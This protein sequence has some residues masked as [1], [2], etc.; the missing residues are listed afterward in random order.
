MAFGVNRSPLL[1]IAT[2]QNHARKCREEFPDASREVQS[3]MHV[4]DCVNGTDYAGVTV[5][6]QQSIDK[7]MELG[8]INLIKWA[9]I[10]KEVLSLIAE[11]ER[12]E[13]ST[14]DFNARERL[15]ALGMC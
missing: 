15:K 1:G 5:E 4:D 11:Q 2:V 7:M 14:I 6:L 10:S 3:N 12:E 9:S 13:S 8:E